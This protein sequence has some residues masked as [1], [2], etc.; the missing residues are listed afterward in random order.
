V[1]HVKCRR[2]ILHEDLRR[3]SVEKMI[4]DDWKIEGE[5]LRDYCQFENVIES[6]NVGYVRSIRTWKMDE[7]K[8]RE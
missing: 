3:T 6:L 8:F 1:Y 5:P 2:V 4:L 7:R